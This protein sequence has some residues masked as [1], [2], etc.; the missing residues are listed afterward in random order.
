MCEKICIKDHEFTK[1][2]ALIN[3]NQ[4]AQLLALILLFLSIGSVAGWIIPIDGYFQEKFH[5]ISENKFAFL[6]RD[7]WTFFLAIFNQ[8]GNYQIH[9]F[10]NP[11]FYNII[12][13][14][15]LIR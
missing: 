6:N 12:F 10:T 15:A 13:Y 8:K 1:N 3:S 2:M 7:N 9:S 14:K 4:T 5:K 11:D